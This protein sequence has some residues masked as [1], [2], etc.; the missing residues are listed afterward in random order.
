MAVNCSLFPPLVFLVV[1][2]LT[3]NYSKSKSQKNIAALPEFVEIALMSEANEQYIVS[4]RKYRPQTFDTV[5]GQQHITTT[6]KNAIRT[7]HLAHAYLFCGP[8]GV[9]KTTC[10]RI[11]ARTLNCE[12]P[13]ENMEACGECSTCQAFSTNSALNIFELDAAS[14]NSVE[15]IRRLTE[16]VRYAPQHGKYKIYI[17]DEVHM[18]SSAA[19]NAFLKTLEEPPSYAI[20]ILATTEKHKILPTILSRCQIF[21]FKRIKPNEI[22]R[23]LQEIIGK[24]GLLAEEAA[25]HIIAQK[26]EGC[27]RDA[28]SMMDRLAGF[29]NG[30]L[31]YEEVIGH[32]N[33]LDATSYFKLSEMLWVKDIAGIL[34]FLDELLQ[35]GFEGDLILNGFEEHFRN[36]LLCREVRMAQL[37][38]I[39]DAHRRHF[40]EHAQV[41]TDSYILSALTILNDAE[42][43]YKNALNKRLH[44]ELCLMKLCYLKDLVAPGSVAV[45]HQAIPEL[46]KKLNQNNQAPGNDP[47]T[48]TKNQQQEIAV[49]SKDSGENDAVE[50]QNSSSNATISISVNEVQEALEYTPDLSSS[51]EMTTAGLPQLKV[52]KNYLSS[53]QQKIN[54]Q[55]QKEQITL[56]QELA[57]KL[58]ASFKQQLRETNLSLSE[59]MG[60]MQVHL[61]ASDELHLLCNS[62]INFAYGKAAAKEFRVYVCKQTGQPAL[63]VI[64]ILAPET[65]PEKPKEHIK[66]RQEVFDEL[67]EKNPALKML[68]HE[69]NLTIE[70]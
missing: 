27:M 56:S 44:V 6:L 23:H 67:M 35:K 37:L 63:R 36:L 51:Q 2:L 58:F 70:Y 57:G 41:L 69:L 32:L 53:L 45:S 28:L 26:S 14:N 34:L 20:F 24:E 54:Q 3:S 66:S 68:K 42:L 17:I 48:K 11:L 4:A 60:M 46:K 9:G 33:I 12:N 5:I 15:D 47:E 8:R 25:L 30:N 22:V 18:L 49:N 61:R 29:S 52:A 39:P 13:T 43:S 59:Q 10:A 65:K 16:Q 7:Q 62:E 38:E 31:S 40:Y 64:A 1:F 21:D 55:E 19:F 50:I